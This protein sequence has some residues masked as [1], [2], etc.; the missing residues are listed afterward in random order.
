[1]LTEPY[2]VRKVKNLVT[3]TNKPYLVLELVSTDKTSING[4]IWNP[5][6]VTDPSIGPIKENESYIFDADESDYQGS[7]QLVIHWAEPVEVNKLDYVK[8]SVIPSDEMLISLRKVVS[9]ILTPAYRSVIKW[10]FSQNDEFLSKIK[11][12]P[13]TV[14]YDYSY[15]GGLLENILLTVEIADSVSTVLKLNQESKDLVVTAS[16]LVDLGKVVEITSDLTKSNDGV[17]L[18]HQYLGCQFLD[19]VDKDTDYEFHQEI[20]KLKHCILTH[21]IDD[22]GNWSTVKVQFLEADIVRQVSQLVFTFGKWNIASKN[23]L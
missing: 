18:G 20:L 15:I 17:Y 3:S 23:S 8:H 22:L 6:K 14:N 21:H 5:D 13:K 2:L 7:R 16:L 1:M 10:V 4:V 12:L 19:E 9:H 11:K